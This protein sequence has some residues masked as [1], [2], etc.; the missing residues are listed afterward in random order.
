MGGGVDREQRACEGQEDA[1]G[2]GPEEEKLE[3]CFGERFPLNV[4]LSSY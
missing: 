3:I 2:Q 1:G 4:D